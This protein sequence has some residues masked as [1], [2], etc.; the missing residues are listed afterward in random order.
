M[1]EERECRRQRQACLL[2]QGPT[3]HL[4]PGTLTSPSIATSDADNDAERPGSPS[5]GKE[6]TNSHALAKTLRV[7]RTPLSYCGP[8]SPTFPCA[9]SEEPP[10][11]GDHPPPLCPSRPFLRTAQPSRTESDSGQTFQGTKTTAS[12]RGSLVSCRHLAQSREADP[13]PHRGAQSRRAVNSTL[14]RLSFL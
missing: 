14:C 5:F 11:P 12:S 9:F 6:A 4:L 1:L 3:C 8:S 10:K 13:R 7:V 2:G